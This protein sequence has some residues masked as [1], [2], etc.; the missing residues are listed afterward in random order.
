[1]GEKREICRVLVANLRERDP[2]IAWRIVLRWT[3]RKWD[4][5]D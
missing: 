3:F 5:V 2:G 4:R 1:M